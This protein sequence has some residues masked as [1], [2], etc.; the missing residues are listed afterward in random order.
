MD[1]WMDILVAD[2]E[3]RSSRSSVMRP[4]ANLVTACCRPA[5][6]PVRPVDRTTNV[7]ML[8]HDDQSLPDLLCTGRFTEQVLRA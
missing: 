2:G 6:W 5:F 7:A 8:S 3:S 1:G 4:A